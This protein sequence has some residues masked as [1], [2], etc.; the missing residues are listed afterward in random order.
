MECVLLLG[1]AQHLRPWNWTGYCFLHFLVLGGFF[2]SFLRKGFPL[3]ETVALYPIP[4]PQLPL[5]SLRKR[6]MQDSEYGLRSETAELWVLSL[7]FI[8]YVSKLAFSQP[9]LSLIIIV[10]CIK[11]V[12]DWKALI[13]VPVTQCYISK[14]Y[15]FFSLYILLMP[16]H[17]VLHQLDTQRNNNCKG[18]IALEQGQNSSHQGVNSM[19]QRHFL[20]PTTVSPAPR[21]VFD[22]QWSQ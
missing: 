22:T 13:A 2:F 5:L 12:S 21:T 15:V 9:L 14:S 18:S 20:S 7:L 19:R 17:P 11:L 10:S 1:D 3:L 16:N 8:S 6:A 4:H